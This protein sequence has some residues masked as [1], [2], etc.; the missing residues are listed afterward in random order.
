M[1]M[2]ALPDFAAARPGRAG[3]LRESWPDFDPAGGRTTASI[4]RETQ[5]NVAGEELFLA[6]YTDGLTDLYLPSYLAF[7]RAGIKSRLF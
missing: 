1:S 4:V 7:A 3:S 2:R 5:K 6:N